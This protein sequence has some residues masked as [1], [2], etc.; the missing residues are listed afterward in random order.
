M[1]RAL[2]RRK[3]RALFIDSTLPGS[4]AS[5]HSITRPLFRLPFPAMPAPLADLF[6][7]L[8]SLSGAEAPPEA[9]LMWAA[10]ALLPIFALLICVIGGAAGAL[11][12]AGAARVGGDDGGGEGDG[13][14]S[15]SSKKSD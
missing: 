8:S 13:S 4:F 11:R 5:P 3:A 15:A 6:T 12:D 1:R 7:L 10:V 14:P 9:A 2:S